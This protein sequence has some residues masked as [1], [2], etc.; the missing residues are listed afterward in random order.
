MLYNI[1]HCYDVDGEFGDAVPKQELIGLVEATDKE[2]ND[3]LNLW[4]KP[5]IYDTPYDA[6][7]EH[8]VIAEPVKIC[9]LSDLQ[10]Y[11]P[12]TR[13]WPDQP[14]GNSFSLMWNGTEWV[15]EDEFEKGE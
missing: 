8:I 11:D 2:V 15:D 13:D 7:Y 14:E 4:N 6:L 1:F 12:V 3:F 10:P 9:E 5:R